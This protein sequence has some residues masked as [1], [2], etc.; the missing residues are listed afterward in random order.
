MKEVCFWR[1]KSGVEVDFVIFGHLGFWAIEVKNTEKIRNED[2]QPLAAFHEDYPEARTL[3][4]Y[5][6]KE[7]VLKNNV[8]CLPCEDFLKG[9]CPNLPLDNGL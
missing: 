7:R 1:T 2:L 9:I 5:R 8:L 3:F 4:L 6:G